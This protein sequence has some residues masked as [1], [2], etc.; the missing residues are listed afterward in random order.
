[1][2]QLDFV[3]EEETMEKNQK[4]EKI[5]NSFIWPFI[6]S[7][8]APLDD[9]LILEKRPSSTRAWRSASEHLLGYHPSP[10][11]VVALN[12]FFFFLGG[13]SL[14]AIHTCGHKTLHSHALRG[15]S[16][17]GGGAWFLGR[18]KYCVTSSHTENELDP[19]LE[20]AA[21]VR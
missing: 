14:V 12:S 13:T 17:R 4:S 20:V 7:G 11:V 21:A 3:V 2:M 19:T 9:F 10:V 16:E 1:M 18:M 5:I 8:K 6:T 15:C